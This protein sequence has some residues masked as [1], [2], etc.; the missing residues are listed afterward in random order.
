MSCLAA[1]GLDE[2]P[3]AVPKTN[4]EDWGGAERREETANCLRI[5]GSGIHLAERCTRHQEGSWA[6]VRPE[7][8][9][10]P[11]TTGN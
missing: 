4:W 3:G 11:E 9:D 8:D 6:K 5:L 2:G 10:W 7:Q 1:G